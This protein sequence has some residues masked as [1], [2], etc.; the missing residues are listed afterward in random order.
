[1]ALVKKSVKEDQ[2]EDAQVVDTQTEVQTEN[3]VDQANE[4]MQAAQEEQAEQAVETE[5]V[6]ETV[7]EPEQVEETEE[8][9]V[10]EPAEEQVTEAAA[11]EE[12][13]EEPKAEPAKEVKADEPKSEVAVVEKK[14]NAPA[15]TAQKAAVPASQVLQSAAD[16]GFEGLELGFGSFPIITLPSEGVFNDSDDN[17]LGKHIRAEIQQSQASYLY[18][19]EGVNDGPVAYSYDRINLTSATEDGDTTVADLKARWVEEGYDM[20]EKKYLE[21]IATIAEDHEE[22]ID[23]EV[24]E[25]LEDLEGEPVMFRIPPASLKAFSGKVATLQ[26]AGKPVKGAVMD[27]MVGKKRTNGANKYFPW[28]FRL[29]K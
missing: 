20:E 18:K 29:V 25:G 26:M 4:A 7:S 16:D 12:K 21:V 17:E 19:Q 22:V 11:E 10:E 8:E 1:M 14:V 13:V 28:K 27:F 3:V 5:T 9:Q 15:T 23:G 2:V 6:N 24:P